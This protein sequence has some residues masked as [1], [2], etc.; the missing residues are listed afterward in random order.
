M[1]SRHHHLLLDIEVRWLSRVRVLTFLFELRK[2][3][4]QFLR[5][6][7]SPLKELSFDEMW[8]GKLTYVA[9]VFSR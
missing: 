4:S 8:T 3:A 1:V 9:Y 6:K 7:N 2:E 5:E